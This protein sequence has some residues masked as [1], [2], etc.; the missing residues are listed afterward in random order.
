MQLGMSLGS[1]CQS[2][3]KDPHLHRDGSKKKQDTEVNDALLHAVTRKHFFFF[4][5]KPLV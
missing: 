5:A 2:G 3:E 4:N 1:C